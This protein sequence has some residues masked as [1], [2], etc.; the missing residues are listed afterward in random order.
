MFYNLTYIILSSKVF[1]Y[2]AKQ[3]WYCYG[4]W[5]VILKREFLLTSFLFLVF[6]D[7]KSVIQIL[8]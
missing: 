5:F 2:K 6:S 8:F 1:K 4:E 7:K 3:L